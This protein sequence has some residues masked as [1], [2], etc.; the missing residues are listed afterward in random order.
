MGRRRQARE[1]ALQALYQIDAVGTA[2]E[3][4][5]AELLHDDGEPVDESALQYARVLVCGVIEH[6]RLIDEFIKEHSANWRLDRMARVDRNVL[7]MA[8]YE[9]LHRPDVPRKVVLNEAIEVAKRF[10]TEESGAFINGLL[11]KIASSIRP[12][13]QEG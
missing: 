6:L 7:R 12:T 3:E 9:L 2:P 11:D 4:A 5:L 1:K 8:V 10:G 13:E